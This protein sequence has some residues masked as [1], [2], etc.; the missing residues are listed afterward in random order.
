[1][2]ERYRVIEGVSYYM[3]TSTTVSWM[4][5]FISA[6]TCGVITSSLSYCRQNKGLKVYAY[7][8]MPTHFHAVVST[9]DP[10]E[11][12]GIIRDVKRHTSRELIRVLKECGWHLPLKVFRAAVPGEKGNSEY[13][14]WQDAFHPKGIHTEETLR[15]KIEYV[16]FNPVR[17]GL[18]EN[19]SDWMYSSARN[20]VSG[21]QTVMEI[22]GL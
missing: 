19:A 15:Q 1:M 4:P 21:M 22:D 2:S 12:S 11:L 9:N 5:V 18:V 7:V 16:H 6:D 13:K 8:V 17:K 3:V 10:K 14:V 20:Y